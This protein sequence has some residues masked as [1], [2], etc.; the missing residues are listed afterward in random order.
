VKGA[1]LNVGA[2]GDLKI[3]PLKSLIGQL[4]F[5]RGSGLRA[6]GTSTLRILLALRKATT[7]KY[8]VHAEDK[9]LQGCNLSAAMDSNTAGRGEDV[10]LP[11]HAS[12]RDRSKS[13][14]SQ[15][16]GDRVPELS[17]Q[18]QNSNDINPWQKCVSIFVPPAFLAE[19]VNWR[20]LRILF[21]AAL[22]SQMQLVFK[23]SLLHTE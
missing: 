19:P 13:E 14:K 11:R 22:R 23:T 8:F 18:T 9:A 16:F 17:S 21:R 4:D 12:L 1:V 2:A 15:G 3:D 5:L 7:H 10:S 20:D 6:P